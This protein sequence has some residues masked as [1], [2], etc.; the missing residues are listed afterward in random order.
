MKQLEDG[1]I[2]LDLDEVKPLVTGSLKQ[3]GCNDENADAVAE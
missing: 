2:N 1:S 3:A